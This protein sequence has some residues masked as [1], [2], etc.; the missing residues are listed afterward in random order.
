M[1]NC[2]LPPTSTPK[3]GPAP[4]AVAFGEHWGVGDEAAPTG[5]TRVAPTARLDRVPPSGPSALRDPTTPRCRVQPTER[6]AANAPRMKA[7]TLGGMARRPVPT[8]DPSPPSVSHPRS[9]VLQATSSRREAGNTAVAARLDLPPEARQ[10]PEME[11]QRQGP[12]DRPAGGQPAATAAAAPRL[13]LAQLL[14]PSTHEEGLYRRLRVLLRTGPL[15]RLRDLGTRQSWP[16]TRAYDPELLAV[17][18]F[19]GVVL[20]SGLAE[21]FDFDA[22]VS[23]VAQLAWATEPDAGQGEWDAV[24]DWVVRSL[25]GDGDAAGFTVSHGDFR[26]GFHHSELRWRLLYERMRADGRVVLQ[27][28]TE[29]INALRAGL[30]LDVE[31]AQLAQETVLRAQLERGDL[32]GAEASAED[33]LR[34]SLELSAKLRDLVDAVALNLDTVDWESG[35]QAKV[36]RSLAHVSQRIQAEH[37]MLSHLATGVDVDD[38][39]VRKRTIAIRTTLERCLE[40]HRDLH[41]LL[42]RA[43]EVFLSE[44]VRQVL[45]GRRRARLRLSIADDLL[46]PTLVLP[47]RGAE[48]VGVTFAMATLGCRPLQVF[49]LTVMLDR[50]LRPPRAELDEVVATDPLAELL[51]EVPDMV[52]ETWLTSPA[53]S[54]HTSLTISA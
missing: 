12:V 45:P 38:A 31:D 10:G 24:A 3:G 23:Y 28:T 22:L 21:E 16:A 36:A 37:Q 40:R 46:L 47:T 42:Q 25:L 19:D 5:E 1:A 48:Q 44:Q 43:P 11:Q 2:T 52:H 18:A 27:A 54:T 50:L 29:G 33:A 9:S 53:C 30:D 13:Q 35:F 14:D 8:E 7:D 15:R 4:S 34:L 26:G 41:R 20:R 51:D 6:P 39:D 32:R 17:V 49:D